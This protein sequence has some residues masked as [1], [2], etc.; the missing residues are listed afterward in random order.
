MDGEDGEKG[1]ILTY[2]EAC[3]EERC[4]EDICEGDPREKN[5]KRCGKMGTGRGEAEGR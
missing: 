1:D 2:G 3:C 5:G 4:R